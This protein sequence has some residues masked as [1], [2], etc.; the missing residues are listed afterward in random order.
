MFVAGTLTLPAAASG[1]V[2]AILFIFVLVF[3]D[4]LSRNFYRAACM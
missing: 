3:D 4:I 1:V 2:R